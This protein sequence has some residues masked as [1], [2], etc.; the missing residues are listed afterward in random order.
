MLRAAGNAWMLARELAFEQIRMRGYPH[1]PPRLNACF[2]LPTTRLPLTIR[3]GFVGALNFRLLLDA[4]DREP[5]V[6]RD[7]VRQGLC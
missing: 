3:E 6:M 5:D 1:K 4:V 7:A 2:G